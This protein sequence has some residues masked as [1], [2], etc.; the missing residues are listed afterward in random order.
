MPNNYAQGRYY[1]LSTL[2]MG[3][4]KSRN[5]MTVRLAQ[6]IGMAPIVD[7]GVRT[8][9]YDELSPVLAMALGAGETTPWR[10]VGA[11]ASFINGGKRVEPT[12][13]D[14]VQDRNGKTIYRSDQRECTGCNPK[15]ED[16]QT[17]LVEPHL[18]DTRPQ[19][20]DPIT[21][22]QITSIMEGVVR[23][24]TATRLRV[25]DK[26]VAGKTGTTNDYKDA[27]FMGMSP[28]LVVG[29][30]VGF[31]SPK[32]LGRGEAGG[33]VAAPIARDFLLEALKNAPNA[34][35]RIPEGVRLVR[36]NGRTGKLARPGEPG[37]IL[38]AFRPGTEP[39]RGEQGVRLTI[40][41]SK[42]VTD[43]AKAPENEDDDLGGLY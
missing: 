41:G 17:V 34:P 14:C 19:D 15:K 37:S 33:R 39:K 2:R 25:I 6:Q 43:D 30:Y 27:W 31:D 35:F 36:V 22:Y 7:I 10:L 8:G 42:A 26:P 29:V 32:T 40:G 12:I 9:I 16:G 4:E 5:V 24:G 28:D 21:A 18:P 23:R 38:E 11:Y 3:I 1:G 13:I 20:L